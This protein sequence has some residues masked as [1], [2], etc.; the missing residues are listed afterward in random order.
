MRKLAFS[1]LLLQ[2]CF[3]SELN[4]S[5][6]V[7]AADGIGAPTL[8]RI[9][10]ADLAIG[11]GV[12]EEAGRLEA[13]LA[14]VL[15]H[16]GHVV[17]DDVALEHL[18]HRERLALGEVVGDH[19]QRATDDAVEEPE[20]LVEPVLD[21]GQ[22][23]VVALEERAERRLADGHVAGLVRLG[24]EELAGAGQVAVEHADRRDPDEDEGGVGH[25]D[26]DVETHHRLEDVL[27]GDDVLEAH[28]GRLEEEVVALLAKM[29]DTPPPGE[30]DHEAQ[31]N[32]AQNA[33]VVK[34]AEKYYRTMVR[35][36][37]ASW[38]VRDRHMTET[39]ERLMER[40]DPEAKGIVWEHNTHI[41]DARFTDMVED[42][43]VNV[44]QLVRE[45]HGPNDVVLV[46]FGSHRGSVIAGRE[47]EAPMQQMH[48]PQGRE[49]SWEDVLHEAGAEDK[50]LVF[51]ERDRTGPLAIERGHRAIGV[52]YHP[53][54][55]GGNYVPTVLPRRYDAFLFVV[56]SNALHPLHE[57]RPR[58]EHEV[59]ETY[60]TGV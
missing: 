48:V 16:P 3:L 11:H 55:E 58:D 49:G 46:G 38:N 27:A 23:P 45:A 1:L 19:A 7:V 57:V 42:G 22:V 30:G 60:P 34:N 40:H 54:R 44:G 4:A 29:R 9:A 47:W 12:V 36:G 33:L 50:L 10:E 8:W 17:V 39:L 14:E 37:P 25:L 41:G 28:L 6:G 21:L 56:Q 18:P 2:V 31:F 32:A 26:Q 5:T 15:D 13:E 53:E 35:G 43:T 52:V 20:P 51:R 24:G 59:P